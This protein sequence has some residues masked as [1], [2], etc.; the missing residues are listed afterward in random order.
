MTGETFK[1]KTSLGQN[2]KL[3]RVGL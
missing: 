1:L 3:C 2:L